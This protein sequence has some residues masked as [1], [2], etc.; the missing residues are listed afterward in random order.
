ME[1]SAKSADNVQAPPNIMMIGPSQSGKTSLL[2]VFRLASARRLTDAS[3]IGVWPINEHA[4]AI[5]RYSH[6]IS[7]H[8]AINPPATAEATEYQF[9]LT[10]NVEKEVWVERMV[11][12]PEASIW[13]IFGGRKVKVDKG[14]KEKRTEEKKFNLAV[15][16]GRGEDIFG[17]IKDHEMEDQGSTENRLAALVE[18]AANSV[19]LIVCLNTSDS[20]VTQKFFSNF[21]VFLDGVREKRGKVPFERVVLALT[22]ADRRVE[23][24]GSSALMKLEEQNA[25]EAAREAIGFFA[26]SSLF[27]ALEPSARNNVYAGWVS[28]YGFIPEEGS[29]NFDSTTDRV[30]IFQENAKWTDDWHPYGVLEPFLFACTG[31]HLKLEKVAEP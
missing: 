2:S 18:L 20:L 12:E 17:T 26:M 11:E 31:R 1:D 4:K 10:C 5:D 24:L 7:I 14:Y 27:G 13:G 3:K 28:V 19:A 23:D 15:L 21:Q 22:Q 30:A 29:V 9:Q 8:G 6:E 25:A 16:D